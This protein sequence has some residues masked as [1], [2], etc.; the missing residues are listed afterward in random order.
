MGQQV[1]V[2]NRGGAGAI[3]GTTL[4]ARAAPDGYTLLLADAPHGA[5]P[6]LHSKL[7]YDTLRDFASISLV[8][9]MPRSIG[10]QE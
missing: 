10:G 2:D 9:L 8:S 5:N 7:P 3:I 6:A 4:A 1:V